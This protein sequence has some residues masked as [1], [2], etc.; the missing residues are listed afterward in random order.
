[1]LIF[2]GETLAKER[3]RHRVELEAELSKLRV[4]APKLQ[5]QQERGAKRLKAVPPAA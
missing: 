1:L 5:T 3:K 2:V 4:G